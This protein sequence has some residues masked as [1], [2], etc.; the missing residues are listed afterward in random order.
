M[1]S[2]VLRRYCGCQAW[3]RTGCVMRQ[4]GGAWEAASALPQ[5]VCSVRVGRGAQAR[6]RCLSDV[7]HPA[8]PGGRC[9]MSHCCCPAS[10]AATLGHQPSSP[11]PRCRARPG[12]LVTDSMY[13]LCD[14][15]VLSCNMRTE[16]APLQRVLGDLSSRTGLHEEAVH[17]S[18]WEGQVL[19][20]TTAARMGWE[21]SPE[22]RRLGMAPHIW[23]L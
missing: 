8:A 23:P 7:P 16:P 2:I 17:P 21:G 10:H 11:A 6:T 3:E 22:V 1:F 19:T 9:G 15:R 13:L 5:A 20:A 12:F 14:L 18:C 4:G